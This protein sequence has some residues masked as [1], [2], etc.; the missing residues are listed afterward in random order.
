MN[1]KI[2]KYGLLQIERAGVMKAQMCPFDTDHVSECGDWCPLFGEPALETL[3]GSDRLAL[4]SK[5]A[6]VLH[7]CHRPLVLDTLTDERQHE[8]T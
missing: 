1:G 2:D 4:T 8:T 7:L 5:S 3:F 6:I